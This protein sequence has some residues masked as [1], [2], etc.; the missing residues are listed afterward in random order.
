M[1]LV[2]CSEANAG[3][4]LRRGVLIFL[5]R[6]GREERSPALSG[7]RA[8]RKG[9]DV[10]EKGILSSQPEII[11]HFDGLLSGHLQNDIQNPVSLFY[12]L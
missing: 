8:P 11:I 3:S 5:G 6:L 9:L 7:L 1:A 4:A 10:L 12:P 2:M